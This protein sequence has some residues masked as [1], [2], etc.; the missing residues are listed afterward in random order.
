MTSLA[1][2]HEAIAPG[3]PV[4]RAGV[5]SLHVIDPERAGHLAT[6]ALAACRG[7]DDRVLVIGGE[8]AAAMAGWNGLA[9]D[10]RVPTTLGRAE[11][12]WRAAQR[13]GAE[14]D[15]GGERLLTAWSPRCAA[16]CGFAFARRALRCI[17]LEADGA[18]A[19]GW[20]R[21]R[22]RSVRALGD[23]ALFGSAEIAASWG[24]SGAGAAAPW[25]G[26]APG[27]IPDADDA[28]V[29]WGL[30]DGA[31]I[32]ALLGDPPGPLEGRRAMFLVGVLAIAG[33]PVHGV[34]AH[35]AAGIERARRLI[36]RQK[37][38]W[39]V[40]LDDR[41]P[42]HWL[43]A[44]DAAIA[45]AGADG[46]TPLAVAWG[47]RAGLPTIV[48]RRAAFASGE[49]EDGAIAVERGSVNRTAL[50]LL[51]VIEGTHA[52]APIGRSGAHERAVRSAWLA[53]LEQA[54]NAALVA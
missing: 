18:G 5:P 10:A 8:R 45:F 47:L 9:F 32:V 7:P 20:S 48:E 53:A 16:L 44:C 31:P 13:L 11:L 51:E 15:P 42:P 50:L 49:R 26:D 1:A 4:G 30:D 33:T 46:V 40:A 14:I 35:D 52:R 29:R 34:A 23:R 36:G 28:R 27:V 12:A 3:A 37:G 6:A 17:M 39:S 38:P 19:D 43:G 25:L 24:A 22:R 21:L 41:P 54:A 2:A